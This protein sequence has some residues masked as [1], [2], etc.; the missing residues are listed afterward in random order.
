MGKK[1]TP[2]SPSSSMGEDNPENV[3]FSYN[4][5]ADISARYYGQGLA[6]IPSSVA[7]KI[8]VREDEYVLLQGGQ[9]TYARC[10]IMAPHED[11]LDAATSLPPILI[12]SNI[13]KNADVVLG[14][15]VQI[16]KIIPIVADRVV[17]AEEEH[18]EPEKTVLNVQRLHKFLL[19][20]I[21]CKSGEV[22]IPSNKVGSLVDQPASAGT[23]DIMSFFADVYY[24][25][26]H[27]SPVN[28][29]VP[30][31]ITEKTEIYI[32]ETPVLDVKRIPD[33]SVIMADIGGMEKHINQLREFL[34][35]KVFQT[36]TLEKSKLKFSHAVLL[37]GPSGLGKSFLAQA[38][39]NEFPVCSY[40]INGPEIIGDKPQSTPQE[41]SKIFDEAIRTAPSVI[42]ID[43]VEALAFNR[44]DLKFDAVTRAIV[45]EFLHLIDRLSVVSNVVL[46]GTTNQPKTLDA[47]FRTTN[48][49]SK[50]IVLSPP[51][52][53]ERKAILDLFIARSPF[54][55]KDAINT[56]AI[57]EE[58]NGFTGADIT[59]FFQEVFVDALK[60][61]GLYDAFISRPLR[62]TDVLPKLKITTQNFANVLK[63]KTLKPSLLR[64]YL[65]ETPKIKFNDVGGLDEAKKVLEENIKFPLM[66]PDIYQKFGG[67]QTKGVLLYGPPGCGKTLLA[68]ALASETSMNFIYIKGAEVLNRWLGESEAAIREIFTKARAAAPCIVFFDELDAI[69]T[70]RGVEGNVHSDRVTAQI[71]T[72]LDGLEELKDVI[73]I[74]AT[75]RLD[76]IDPAV[77]RPGRLYPTIKIDFPTE[78]ERTII[79]QIH[80]R[81]MPLAKDVDLVEISRLTEGLGGATLEEICN[82]ASLA[83]IRE[84]IE[85]FTTNKRISSASIERRHFMKAI[86]D[87]KKKQIALQGKPAGFYT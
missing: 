8:G 21:I 34:G 29:N 9:K 50:E 22:W 75:N 6:L 61:N 73:C 18:G 43:E 1:I 49:F 67:R 48:R 12:D 19:N 42:I 56:Q 84:A 15:K 62:F 85:E 25:V 36:E 23:P 46:I 86:E 82:H 72:E 32:R 59:L 16:E 44:D 51:T 5:V 83:A 28:R 3:Q 87:I 57:A 52:I 55:D 74:G 7:I 31:I 37:T 30:A 45:T 38:I 80:S 81:K 13:R 14:D 77:M 33:N 10:K 64:S 26:F 63:A 66:Y 65:V 78:R 54:F 76:I 53:P 58:C 2:L 39:T 79:L 40:V 60:K 17:L 35:F 71:L 27:I 20:H 24:I 69:S 70:I 68:K 47:A 11:Y 4:V 41:L